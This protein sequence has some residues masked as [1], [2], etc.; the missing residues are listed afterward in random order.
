[1][2]DYYN[3]LGL[4]RG[5]SADEIKKAYR[6]AALK[7][8]PD[9][10]PGDP[11]AEKKFK[12]IS[13]AYE[14]L[15]DD[16]KRQ[17]YDQYGADALRGGM[18]AG[19]GGFSNME[20]ALRTFMGAFGGAGGGESIFDT[21]FGG[22]FG[23]AEAQAAEQG[24]SK[25]INLTVSFTEA[26]RGVEKEVAITNFVTCNTCHGSGAKS[27]SHIKTCSKCGGSGYVHQSRGFFSM[28]APCSNC[29]GRGQAISEYCPNCR[30]SGRVKEKETIK[31]KVPA[32]IDNGMRLRMSGFG[33]AGEGGG[34]RGDLYVFITV[35]P[36]EFF[37]REEDNVVVELPISFT[38]AALGCKK[39][40]PTPLGGTARLSIS[41]GTQSGK[42]LR[43]RGEGAPNVHGHGKG[44]LLVKVVVETP[45]GLSDKQ[46]ALLEEFHALAGE[47]NSPQRG[48]FLDKI[49]NFFGT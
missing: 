22:G 28:S 33:D 24:A 37:K 21:F 14:V 8:H 11:S 9:K 46:K 10:N 47:H 49:K 5:A 17:I 19:A 30:G 32:G 23:G 48:S 36:H 20:D 2:A 45:V 26:M 25:K 15:S 39:E 4:N 29:H 12:E 34:P 40:L 18:G 41:E 6:K 13:E 3:I 35:E 44:D 43:V 7:Y 27:S 16:K 42:I 1:M 31:I 38:E